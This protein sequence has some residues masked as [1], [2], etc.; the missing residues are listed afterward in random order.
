MVRGLWLIRRVLVA[1]LRLVD[2]RAS[3]LREE[4]AKLKED[5]AAAQVLATKKVELMSQVSATCRDQSQ[6]IGKLTNEKDAAE[7][8]CSCFKG[9]L[10]SQRAAYEI[11]SHEQKSKYVK[12]IKA[13]TEAR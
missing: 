9:E 6:T 12:E 10:A 4:N 11:K 2:A 1:E 8:E 7:A 5:L 3:V 13:N